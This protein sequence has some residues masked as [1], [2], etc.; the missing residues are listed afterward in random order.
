[1][2]RGNPAGRA[3][4]PGAASHTKERVVLRVG[5]VGWRGMVG[6]V[7][8]DRM[9]QCGDFKGIEP[10]FFSTSAAGTTGP[11]IE[12]KPQPLHDAYDIQKLKQLDVLISCQGGG[13]TTD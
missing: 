12:A 5:L 8:L 6:S 11:T 4:Q 3:L 7:L 1:M 13:Y 2:L 10:H 9:R